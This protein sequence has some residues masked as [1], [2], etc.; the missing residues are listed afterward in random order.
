MADNAIQKINHYQAGNCEQNVLRSPLDGDL[1]SGLI[2]QGPQAIISKWSPYNRKQ[3]NKQTMQYYKILW[4]I[5]IDFI[6]YS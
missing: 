3:T 2:S 1:C 5:S 4:L 6:R